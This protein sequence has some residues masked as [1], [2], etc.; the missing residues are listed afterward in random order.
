MMTV[1]PKQFWEKK[2][3][4]WERGRYDAPREGATLL[5]SVANRS[6]GSLRFRLDITRQ[7]LAPYVAGKHVVEVGCGSGLLAMD[8]L[9][10]GAASYTGY[11]IAEIAVTEARR[12]V[13]GT[14]S[15]QR[16]RFE[17]CSVMELPKLEA[18]IVFSLGL[19]DWLTDEELDALFKATGSSDYLHAIS[20]KG[21]S[22]AQW[23]HRAY[24]H[25]SYGRRTGSYVPRY[26]S[27]AWL[28]PLIQ[29]HNPADVNVFRHPSLSFGALVSS[30]PIISR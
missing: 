5:E 24:V 17:V 26:Y 3:L 22:L 29:R 28:E 10:K 20:E 14:K 16:A 8:I 23:L 21:R 15:G 2:I 12:R 18:D 6:S 9:D 25:L 27:V 30:L 11:D 1:D 7:L 4:T 19:L 13:E